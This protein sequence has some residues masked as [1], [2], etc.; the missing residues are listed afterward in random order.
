MSPLQDHV[1]ERVSK[2]VPS[3]YRRSVSNKYQVSQVHRQVVSNVDRRILF[4]VQFLPKR[5]RLVPFLFR[6]CFFQNYEGHVIRPKRE[7]G[8]YQVFVVFVL[9]L[10]MCPFHVIGSVHAARRYATNP[11]MVATMISLVH[12]VISNPIYLFFRR[13]MHTRSKGGG[14]SITIV[15]PVIG[16]QRGIVVR[17]VRRQSSRVLLPILRPRFQVLRSAFVDHPSNIQ[18]AFSTIVLTRQQATSLCPELCQF[19]PIV[20]TMGRLVSVLPTPFYRQTFLAVFVVRIFVQREFYLFQVTS[21]VR[22]S[23]ISVMSIRRLL[24]WERRVIKDSE[25][26]K[27]WVPFTIVALTRFQLTPSGQRLSLFFRALIHT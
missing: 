10:V 4:Q 26:T 19:R 17:M 25:G 6:P 24:C 27:I 5:L 18:G 13:P 23:T 3:S 14:T 11:S 2:N 16:G 22:V 21:V 20:G 7:E 12:C 15:C 9:R 1:S 8:L